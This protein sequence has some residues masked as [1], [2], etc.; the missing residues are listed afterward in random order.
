[1]LATLMLL[2]LCQDPAPSAETRAAAAL[3]LVVLKNG[4]RLE[5]RITAQLDGYVELE[6]EAGASIGLAT[7]Q[8]AEVRR[9]AGAALAAARPTVAPSD[10][11]FVLHDGTGAAV[12][13]LHAAAKPGAD[14]GFSIVEEYEFA[15]GRARWQVTSM[16]TADA[17]WRPISCYFRERRSDPLLGAAPLAMVD[18]AAN[19]T[20]IVDERI[21]E[22]VRHDDRLQ[23]V[24]LDRSGR[25]ERTI[26]FPADATFPLLARAMARQAKGV[27]AAMPIFDPA[28]DE[29]ARRTFSG[30]RSRRVT[31]DGKVARV[32]EVAECSAVGRNSEWIDGSSR[33]LRRELAGPALV[34]VATDSANVQR[35]SSGGAIPGAV[36]AEA[37]GAFGVWVPNPAWQASEEVP[38][39]QVSLQ[40][41]AHG[42]TIGLSRIEHLEPGASLDTATTAVANWFQLLHTDLRIEGRESVVVRERSRSRLTARSRS[43]PSPVRATIDVIPWRDSFLVLVCRA[44]VA[45]WDELEADFA[46][47]QRSIELDA[48]AIAPKQQGPLAEPAH[49]GVPAARKSVPAAP[50]PTSGRP[51]PAGPVV[52]IPN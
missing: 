4:D 27:E 32:L 45:A 12:G 19:A 22:A 10:E 14:G 50:P 46:F 13:W 42:A 21:V 34:A 25:R 24:R 33:T 35:A 38:A 23:I 28:T 3:D 44:P 6:I 43:G 9:G 37:G 15:D 1:M 51:R 40:C 20:R 18:V 52:R 31:I 48:Q 41:D 7:T 11:W 8:I 2:C 36:V 17:S 16:C 39:G 29:M 30:A 5:G 47:V 26:D 49:K